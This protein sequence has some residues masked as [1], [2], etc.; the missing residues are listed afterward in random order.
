M[1]PCINYGA[2]PFFFFC[3]AFPSR[4]YFW[5]GAN[6]EGGGGVWV[7]VRVFFCLFP[8]FCIIFGG[9]S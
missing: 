8:P 5:G 3:R 7:G 9:E 4:F 6:E 2:R 1:V